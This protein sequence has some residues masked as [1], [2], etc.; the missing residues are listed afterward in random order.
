LFA[1]DSSIIF[2]ISDSTDYAKEFTATFDKIHV[3]FTIN[4]LSLN[5]N[6]TNYVHFTAKTNTEIDIN[7][8][9]KNIQINNTYNIKFLGWTIYNTLSWNKEI[10]KL[11]SELSSAGYSIS[12]PLYKLCLKRSKNLFFFMFNIP[13]HME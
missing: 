2:S 12:D 1:E 13:C 3:W 11:V 5:L 6:K 4:S 9:F 8:N 7:I 10:E